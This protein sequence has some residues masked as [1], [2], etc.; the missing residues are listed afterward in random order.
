MKIGIIGW[1][2]IGRAIYRIAR[3]SRA[4]DIVVIDDINPDAESMAYLLKYDSIYGKLDANII[5]Q[6]EAFISDGMK[7]ALYH[8]DSIADVPWA[9]H[10]VDVVIDSSGAFANAAKARDVLAD[11]VKKVVITHSPKQVIPRTPENAIVDHTIV[12]GVT[13]GDYDPESHHVISS[14]I[15]D[16]TALSPVVKVLENHFGIEFGF[17][18]T[19]HPWLSYQ[20]LSDGPSHS[21]SYP[22]KVYK[23]Y[24][25]GRA[26]MPS[27]IPKPTTA[28]DATYELVPEMRGKISELSYRVPTAIVSSSD[29]SLVLRARTTTEEV[30]ALFTDYQARQKWQTYNNCEDPLVSIDYKES[31]YA[32]NI[33]HRWTLVEDGNRL[34]M[35]LWYDNEW[36]YS[37]Q[38]VDMVRY[39]GTCGR[40]CSKE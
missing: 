4:F 7:T 24:P 30:K 23:H 25:L 20:S 21:W 17:I 40:D 9:E 19:L 29:L 15:C 16:A 2:R 12:L 37:S 32:T 10:G 5:V 27:I 39:L 6:N 11:G 22:G 8:L 38:V 1:G 3:K 34:K 28:V 18:T 35:V 14:S 36:G 13:D 31:P 33:D 26:T